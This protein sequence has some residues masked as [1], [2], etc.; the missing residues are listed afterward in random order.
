MRRLTVGHRASGDLLTVIQSPLKRTVVAPARSKSARAIGSSLAI[1]TLRK[2][3]GPLLIGRSSQH[4]IAL[5]LGVLS[6][7]STVNGMVLLLVTEYRLVLLRDRGTLKDRE[8]QRSRRERR[9][10]FHGE[11]AEQR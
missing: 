11:T 3:R 7:S 10:V 2:L 9:A 8:K 1:S 4:F 5:G 6:N